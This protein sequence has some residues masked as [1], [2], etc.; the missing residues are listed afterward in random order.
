MQNRVADSGQI[1]GFVKFEVFS[2]TNPLPESAADRVAFECIQQR[3]RFRELRKKT[4]APGRELFE[5][6][7]QAEVVANKRPQTRPVRCCER[8]RTGCRPR[9]PRTRLAGAY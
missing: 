8:Y 5:A 7:I 6:D 9:P 2:P 3:T 1:S 4:A